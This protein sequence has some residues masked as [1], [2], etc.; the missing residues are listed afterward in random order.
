MS[1]IEVRAPALAH[2]KELFLNGK[3]VRPKSAKM[4]N[5]VS[6]VNETAFA[7]VA[8]ANEADVDL[9]VS[10]ARRAFDEGPWP[11]MKPAERAAKLR[12]IN[13]A[14]SR[15]VEETSKAWTAQTGQP[16]WIAK[17]IDPL[18]FDL[19]N[20]YAAMIESY[21]FEEVRPT[22]AYDVK[23]AMLVKEPVGVVAAIAPWN[24]PLAALVTKVAPA[25]AAGCTVIAKPAPETPLEAFLLAEAVEEAGLPEG[26]FNIAPADRKASDHLISHPGVDKVA[27]TGSTAVGKHIAEVCARRMARVTMELGGKSAA[28][29]LDDMDPESAGKALA[30]IVV[31]FSGQACANLSRILIPKRREREYTDAIVSAMAATPYGD[32]YQEGIA[33]GPLAMK[34]QLERVERYI[35]VGKKEGARIA[36]GGSRAKKPERGYFFEPTVF[37]GVSNTMT[38]A[39]EEIFGPVAGI[40]TYDDEEE[41]I[42]LANDSLY[43]L[44]GA[45]FT[46]DVDRAYKIARRIRTGNFS[47]NTR[48][49]DT[50]IPFGGFK[51]SGYGR[52][53]GAEG[54]SS[55]L[56][57]K[58][59]FMQGTPSHL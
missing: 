46:N 34:R 8:E 13:A 18:V 30:S 54:F 15:R 43:G 56:E 25:L 59:L 44:S 1:V 38:I 41:A 53:G 55:F 27:F 49:L 11:R 24:T 19:F 10:A 28:I 21:P 23:V 17:I 39:Q 45:V 2:S 33:M 42:R 14:L 9:A 47:Q 57:L 40:T 20:Y 48:A 58:A 35:G 7:Q 6:A 52:E 12:A 26:V 31:Q 32:P 37:T 50:T 36:T 5:V 29:V 51:Q 3:W 16:L 22:S 4:L